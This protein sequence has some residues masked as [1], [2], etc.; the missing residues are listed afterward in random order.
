MNDRYA[1][2]AEA[3]VAVTA[4]ATLPLGI[5]AALLLGLTEAAVV[6]VIGWLLL[7]PGFAVLEGTLSEIA[8]TDESEPATESES[9]TES[10][11][12]P[13]AELKSRYAR[14]EIGD[15]EFEAQL[16]RLVAA[17]EIPPGAVETDTTGAGPVSDVD[18]TPESVSDLDATPESVSDLDATPESVSDLDTTPE[19]VAD[20]DTTV[21]SDEESDGTAQRGTLREE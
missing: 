9:T 15:A 20:V 1:K 8:S 4:V 14:G 7:T 6:F 10:A 11:E 17:D 13:L 5:L 18:A 19:S 16:E 12:D 21:E 3:L 2:L